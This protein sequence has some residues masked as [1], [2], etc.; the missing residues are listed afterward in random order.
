MYKILSEVPPP[1]NQNPGA[2]TGTDALN[3][4]KLTIQS[5]LILRTDSDF[6]HILLD[7]Y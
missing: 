3:F 1:P 6:T 4:R 5:N 2:A 7:S